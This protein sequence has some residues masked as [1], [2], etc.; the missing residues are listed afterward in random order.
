MNNKYE[1]GTLITAQ[2][3][4]SRKLIIKRYLKRIYYCNAVDD[5]T[6]KLLVFFERE[7]IDPATAR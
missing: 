7:F 1:E 5:P 4:P 2:N 3:D 6:H